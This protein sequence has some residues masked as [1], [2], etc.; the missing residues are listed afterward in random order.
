MFPVICFTALAL[1]FLVRGR[2]RPTRAAVRLDHLGG[3]NRESK[4]TGCEGRRRPLSAGGVLV[5]PVR[6]LPGRARRAVMRGIDTDARFGGLSPEQLCGLRVW[7]MVSLPI[8]T[9]CLTRFGK[10]GLAMA[11]CACV[12]GYLVPLLAQARDRSRY[13]D[14]VRSG[15]PHVADLLYAFALGGKNLHQSFAG[16]V[17][18]TP[19]PLRSLLS[20]AV[21]EMDLGAS[22]EEAFSRLQS[23]CPL[24]ELSTLLV[25][26]RE[27][28]K[29]GYPM[30][31]TL[32]VFSRELR[33]QHRDRLRV[34]VAKAP[35]KI[36]GP[37]VFLILPASVILTV[38]P[39]FLAALKRGF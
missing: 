21:I 35:L 10:W 4:D 13:M 29:R 3:P 20:R 26:L 19:E 1:I 7:S 23:R 15:L 12:L 37:L 28:E 8:A 11:P 18:A 39:T 16:A 38:G 17:E 24:P 33:L 2:S 5:V 9:V 25:A 30:S 14:A 22:R 27:A 31:G 32:A 6:L 36:L 34:L